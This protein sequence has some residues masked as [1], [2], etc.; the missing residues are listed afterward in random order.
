MSLRNH[1]SVSVRSFRIS[2]SAAAAAALSSVTGWAGSAAA[3]AA[4][5]DHLDRQ[6][7]DRVFRQLVDEPGD[8][9]RGHVG[10]MTRKLL[11]G[12]GERDRGGQTDGDDR[13]HV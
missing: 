2:F 6:V 9:G 10:R 5:V 4:D 13:S 8:L 1:A 3:V 11:R 7:A 12:G